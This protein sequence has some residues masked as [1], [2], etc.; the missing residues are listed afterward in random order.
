[1][2]KPT[3]CIF[4]ASLTTGNMG[5]SALGISLISQIH[6][7]VRNGQI[8]LMIGHKSSGQEV[9]TLPDGTI[10]KVKIVNYRLSPK[11]KLGEHAI[12]I[13]FFALLWRLVPIQQVR[14]KISS[15]NRW[16]HYITQA[17]FIGSIN[18]GDSFSD[19]YG[20]TRFLLGIFPLITAILLK[21]DFVLLPQT[22]GPFKSI[23][24]KSIGCFILRKASQVYTRDKGKTNTICSTIIS[25]IE[26]K[27]TFCADV[28]FCLMPEKMKMANVVDSYR[29]LSSDRLVGFNISGLLLGGGYKKVNT[30]GMVDDY[31]VTVLT[32]IKAILEN[33]FTVVLIPH[34]YG[35][36]GGINNDREACWTIFSMLSSEEKKNVF[37]P[38]IP[39]DVHIVK[40][41]I[42]ETDFFIGSRMH[43]CIAALSQGIPSMAIAYSDKFI[44]VFASVGMD[45]MV[46]DGRRVTSAETVDRIVTGLRERNSTKQHLQKRIEGI[47]K[48]IDQVFFELLQ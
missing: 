26:T 30:F 23:V 16:L 41:V 10:I 6:K 37:I 13:L 46:I 28:A 43:S 21:K 12:G 32:S 42:G 18:G 4:G 34:C 3:A 11:S 9:I 8:V 47:I 25:N 31:G 17:T 1:L 27:V 33:G 14:K 39:A 7:N 24:S 36:P 29:H 15:Y 5:V 2:T 44:G 48:E 20:F 38:N 35:V 40:G 45:D 22:Y 19:I